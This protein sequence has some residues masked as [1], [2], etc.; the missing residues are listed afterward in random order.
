[1]HVDT[2]SITNV[3]VNRTVIVNNDS[4]VAFNGGEGGV[5]VRPTPQQEAYARQPHTPPVA[6]QVQQEHAASQ[7]RALFASENHGAPAVAATARPGEFSGKG[8]VAAK[9]AGAPYHA[10]AMSPKEARAAAPAGKAPATPN[11]PEPA[12]RPSTPPPSTHAA[13]PPREQNARP[14]TEP[15]T[16][17]AP[18]PATKENAPKESAPRAK[19]PKEKAPPK[20]E[21]EKEPKGL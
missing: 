11:R 12:S 7:N 18:H 16:E 10:P 5:A 13:T 6:S 2:V 14:A 20:R 19:P 21:E 4:H 8:V 15:R 3:Y 17:N 9:A 1:M